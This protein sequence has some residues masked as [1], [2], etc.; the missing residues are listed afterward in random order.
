MNRLTKPKFKN[1]MIKFNI[2]T[3]PQAAQEFLKLT[4]DSTLFAFHGTM[5]AGKTTFITQLC[6]ALGVEQD[7]IN[8]PT[9]SI[10]NEYL[11]SNNQ[12][13]YHFDFYR[14]NN[15]QEALDFGLYDYFDSG[16]ICF[17]EWPE[18]IEPLLP[19]HVQHV[20]I[21]VNEDDSRTITLNPQ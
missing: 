15:P 16:N 3:M 10:V 13:L 7:V 17:M 9:F 5:G 14:I 1:L 21:Q 20:Y 12:M 19:D 6:R 11:T 4:K 18:Q 2:D 8:S